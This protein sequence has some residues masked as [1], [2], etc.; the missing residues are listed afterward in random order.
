VV[1]SL[2]H[3][4]CYTTL[5][6]ALT[7]GGTLLLA[8]EDAATDPEALAALSRRHPVDVLKIAPTHLDALLDTEVDSFLPREHLLFGGEPL[9]WPTVQRVHALRPELTVW[10]HYGPT[11]TTIGATMYRVGWPDPWQDRPTVPIGTAITGPV[12][13][14]DGE[15]LVGGPGVARGYLGLP[16]E[17]AAGFM[18]RADQDGT[19]R[20]YRT[21][22]L[23]GELGDGNLEF[24]GRR[25][26]Q[27]SLCGHRVELGAVDAGLRAVPGVVAAAA[28]IVGDGANARLAAG[29]V[30]TGATT[31]GQ[32]RAALAATVPGHLVPG[33]LVPV[34][35]LP[36]TGSGKLDRVAL[37]AEL[38]AR[39]DRAACNGV[40]PNPGDWIAEM[41]RIW[42]DVLELDTVGP[43]DDFF[44]LGGHSIHAIKIVAR[45]RKVFGRKVPI[46]VLFDCLTPRALLDH[47]TTSPRAV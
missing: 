21:G 35:R 6:S 15:L 20:W 38:A 46:R 47:V 33:T 43:E 1:G 17:T 4:L 13:V 26:D 40:V 8:D 34:P 9:R 37:A 10:N 25:D 16:E 7:R 31:P 32:V 24:L 29:V 5:W 2:A 11:E 18:S 36:R 30:L 41:T 19:T 39:P 27:V 23:V 28:C 42:R 22:D 44:E 14:E 12:R 45:V 3:D